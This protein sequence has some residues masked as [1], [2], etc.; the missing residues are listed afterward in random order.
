MGEARRRVEQ[1]LPPRPKTKKSK[2]SSAFSWLPTFDNPR[3]QFY[4]ITRTGSWIGIGLLAIVW[5]VV[6]F[7]GPAFGWWTPADST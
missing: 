2:A 6:R 4:S 1:G 7:V 5:I 3:E